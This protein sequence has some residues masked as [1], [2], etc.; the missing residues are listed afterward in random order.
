MANKIA[1]RYVF[2]GR[3]VVDLIASLPLEIIT[4]VFA[5]GGDNL[6]FLGMLKMVRL[7]RLGRIITFLKANQKLKFSMKIGQ[8]LFFIF[9][10][11]HWINWFWYLVTEVDESWF[12][13]KD[14][15]AKVTKAYTGDKFTIY[16]LYYYYSALILVGSEILPTDNTELLI[17]I[18]LLFLGTIFIGIIIGEFASILSA[19]TK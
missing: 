4:L 12:P 19:I 9:L 17:A 2:F 7:L 11:M 18:L 14:L 13:P 16:T 1:A 10:I 3:F 6:K 8:L 15:D 5:S